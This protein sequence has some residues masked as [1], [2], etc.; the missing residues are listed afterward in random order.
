[1]NKA[2]YI[3]FLVLALQLSTANAQKV[4]KVIDATSLA[5]AGGLPQNGSGINYTIKV[6]LLTSKKVT[7]DDIWIGAKYGLL[8]THSF[9]YADGR[10]LKEGDTALLIYT[11]HEFPEGSPMQQVYNNEVSKPVPIRFKGDALIGFSCGG[12]KRFRTIA[13]FRELPVANYP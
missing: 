2:K 4:F 3:M 7:F 10:T 5:W 11:I 9:S 13:K 6:V 1:M 12:L 8:Q